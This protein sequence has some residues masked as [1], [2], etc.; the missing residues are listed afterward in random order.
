[1]YMEPVK[2]N[3]KEPM[4][5]VI[6][7]EIK[8]DFPIFRERIH[9]RPLIYLDNAASTHKPSV[10]IER[11]KQFYEEENSN[12]HRGV[13]TLSQK[14]TES[15]EAAREVIRE[16][17]NAQ[18]TKE[19]IFVRGTTEGINLV[20]QS[21]GRQKVQA[22]DEILISAMEHHSNIVP[23]QIL[24]NEVGAH[25]KI[26]PMNKKGEL[27]LEELPKLLTN[28]TR[29]VALVHISN[30]LG[31]INPIEYIT[32]EAHKKNIPVLIDGAQSASHMRID[33]QKLDCD[34]FAF[35]GHKLYA[36]MGIGVLYGK[37]AFLES[38]PPFQG[39]GDMIKSVTFEKTIYND[40]PFKFEAGTPNVSGAVGLAEAIRYVNHI[41]IDTIEAFEKNLLEYATKRL[42]EC[43][44][45][46]FIGEASAKSG[47]ISFLLGDVHP[48]DIGTILDEYGIAIRTGHHCA[49][50]VM[51]F[52]GIPATAR[53]SLGIYNTK[54]DIDELIEGLKKVRKVFN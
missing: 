13:H 22:S 26:I 36:P 44:G 42:Q 40:L 9:G 8:R 29:L 49:Q 15:F 54:E 6:G 32:R 48:H 10:V 23:W 43:D 34:F 5:E 51:Q 2:K 41:G 3:I 14:A 18:S 28:R 38:M 12:V 52:F 16:F 37:E 20:A 7:D 33:V 11:V 47:V 17:L 25:L 46:R 53:M 39:G 35:S 31:T 4:H 50:P 30:A 21:Y 1:M 27:I 24:C 45:I 19:I